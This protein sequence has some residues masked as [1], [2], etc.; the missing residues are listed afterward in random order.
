[1]QSALVS[2]PQSELS[3]QYGVFAR[4]RGWSDYALENNAVPHGHV[5][6]ANLND[7]GFFA[8]NQFQGFKLLDAYAQET[9]EVAQQR[10]LVLVRLGKQVINWGES[11]RYPGIN[12]FNP[13][14][15]PRL[16]RDYSS[17]STA[18]PGMRRKSAAFAVSTGKP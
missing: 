11:L 12:V 18:Q 7:S 9:F 4:V 6:G 2:E 13:I 3:G 14:H 8:A 16:A 5:P 10:L 15:A 17:T 1:M